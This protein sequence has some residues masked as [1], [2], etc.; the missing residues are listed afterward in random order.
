M[1]EDNHFMYGIYTGD[2][3]YMGPMPGE[4]YPDLLEE[5]DYN[6]TIGLRERIATL[7]VIKYK[8]NVDEAFKL[9]RRIENYVIT[10]AINDKE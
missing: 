9:A 1:A 5:F 4:I 7:L 3:D 8:G 2:G 10:G 6:A